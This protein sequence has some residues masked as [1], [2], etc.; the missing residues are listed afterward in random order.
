MSH[1]KIPRRPGVS[2]AVALAY[3]PLSDAAPRLIGKGSGPLADRILALA[4]AKGIPIQKDPGLIE[5]LMRVDLEERIPSELY[6]A[7]A[8]VLAI[9]WVAD[10]AAADHSSEARPTSG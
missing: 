3:D 10:R 5:F 1:D 2:K 7:V 8:S 4:K 9:V 6:A